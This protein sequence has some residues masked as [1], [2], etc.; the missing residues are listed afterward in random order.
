M[1]F[2]APGEFF[3]T[4][5]GIRSYFFTISQNVPPLHIVIT[6]LTS[7]NNGNQHPI[8]TLFTHT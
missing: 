8:H 1:R 6:T 2:I 4:A 3:V 5:R 7:G